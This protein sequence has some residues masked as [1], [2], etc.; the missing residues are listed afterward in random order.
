MKAQLLAALRRAIADLE[1]AE[2]LYPGAC[3]QRDELTQMLGRLRVLAE[4]AQQ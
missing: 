3:S 1:L 4:Q 2:A